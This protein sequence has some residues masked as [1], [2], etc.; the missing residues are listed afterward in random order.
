MDGPQ[1]AE[2]TD[3]TGEVVIVRYGELALKSKPVRKDMVQRLVRTIRERMALRGIECFIN[4]DYGRVYVYTDHADKALEVLSRVF[5]IVTC[6]RCTETSS[7]LDNLL[8]SVVAHAKHWLGEG[9]SFAVRARRVGD[10]DYTS[11]E[12]ARELGSAV[13]SAIPGIRVDLEEPDVEINVEVRHGWAYIFRDFVKGPGGLPMGSQGMVLALVRNE[14]D[15]LAA[16]M[17]M[18]RG[19]RVELASDGGERIVEKLREWDPTVRV[20]TID[21]FESFLDLCGE[22][23]AEGIVLGWDLEEIIEKKLK[24]D[25]PIFYPLVGLDTAE[26]KRLA[27]S[28]LGLE[29]HTDE[30]T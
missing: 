28:V 26:K 27:G 15:A 23:K 18:K 8:E 6:S 16:W 9:M 17:M 13:L 30:E 22:V 2:S 20:H 3:R 21:G 1:R 19:C 14:G 5:G 7:E 4:S 25:V 29:E 12:L 24:R 10:H 11:Q